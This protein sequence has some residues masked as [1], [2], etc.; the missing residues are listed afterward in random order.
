M[1]FF[2]KPRVWELYCV[3]FCFYPIFWILGIGEIAWWLLLFSLLFLS[4]FYYSRIQSLFFIIFLFG[5]ILSCFFIKEEGRW[6][7]SVREIM[8]I[9]FMAGTFLYFSRLDYKATKKTVDS[10]IK[11]ALIASLLGLMCSLLA[12]DFD[13][14]TPFAYLVPSELIKTDYGHRIFYASPVTSSWFFWGDYFRV[15]SFFSYA[16]SCAIALGATFFLFF[17]YKSERKLLLI[18]IMTILAFAILLT[19]TRSVFI[20]LF[21][22][23]YAGLFFKAGVIGRTLLLFLAALAAFFLYK[24]GFYDFLLAMRGGGSFHTRMDIYSNTIH[25]IGFLGHGAYE[26]IPSLPLPLG[27]HST[28][29]GLL[30]KYGALGAVGIFLFFACSV[31]V[32]LHSSRHQTLILSFAVYLIIVSF[33][34]EV[35]LDSLAAIFVSLVMGVVFNTRN[36]VEGYYED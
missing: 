5:A 26:D 12:W 11:L 1:K 34:E 24:V 2:N 35:Y 14:K 4:N 28:V 33:F 21:V 19:S 15:S 29:L 22:S 7:Q 9:V 18:V 10:V 16:T 27:S 32:A 20:A 31:L 17:K 30:F 25:N 8:L 23:M 3:Y 36:N 13:F 6:L